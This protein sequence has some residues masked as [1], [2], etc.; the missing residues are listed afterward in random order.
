MPKSKK[1]T[2]LQ[3]LSSILLAG[4]GVVLTSISLP[5]CAQTIQW[6]FSPN[7]NQ[8]G[9]A[10]PLLMVFII[11]IAIVCW[12]GLLFGLMALGL[13]IFKS[14]RTPI[15]ESS[16]TTERNKVLNQ[17]V[18]VFLIISAALLYNLGSFT[19]L[20]LAVLIV[21]LELAT[22]SVAGTFAYKSGDRRLLISW[23]AAIMLLFV[24]TCMWAYRFF[25]GY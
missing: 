18:L 4:L 9:N 3:G 8:P 23:G 16:T 21:A 15:A 7:W 2:K 22:L 11:P 5:W 13:A 25:M 19:G 12:S 10:M 24:L 1:V 6:I 20:P 17:R 14:L